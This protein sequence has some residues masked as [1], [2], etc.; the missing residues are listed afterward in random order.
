MEINL[1]SVLHVFFYNIVV[2]GFKKS[3][4]RVYKQTMGVTFP[5]KCMASG[6]FCFPLSKVYFTMMAYYK[7]AHI[8]IASRMHLVLL[9]PHLRSDSVFLSTQL[10]PVNNTT[11]DMVTIIKQHVLHALPSLRPFVSQNLSALLLYLPGLGDELGTIFFSACL[12]LL[13]HSPTSLDLWRQWH[14]HQL[15]DVPS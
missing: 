14:M 5:S 7:H 12:V 2:H 8:H 1:L 6:A 10:S 4:S 11:R 15:E 9:L 13:V 3:H